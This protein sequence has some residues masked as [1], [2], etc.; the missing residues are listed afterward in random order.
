M[1]L[2]RHVMDIRDE[3][4]PSGQPMSEGT[5]EQAKNTKSPKARHSKASGKPS[6]NGN[7]SHLPKDLT[8][9]QEACNDLRKQINDDLLQAIKEVAD[10]ADAHVTLLKAI[11]SSLT[12]VAGRIQFSGAVQANEQLSGGVRLSRMRTHSWE[13]P[14]AVERSGPHVTRGSVPKPANL[15]NESSAAATP[16]EDASTAFAGNYQK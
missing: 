14:S 13:A 15:L 6:Q 9:I 8:H 3:I 12:P 5:E 10:K 16:R 7:E 11:E 1:G 4:L 2:L